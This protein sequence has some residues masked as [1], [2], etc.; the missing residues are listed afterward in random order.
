MYVFLDESGDLGFTLDQPYR[1]GGSSRYL[2]ISFLLI[3]K[4]LLQ[5]PKRIVKKIY[6]K[7]KRSAK[8]ELKGADL[9]ESENIFVAK[10]TVELINKNPQ[11]R[12]FAITVYKRNVADHIRKDPNKL[13]N[14]M[15]SL[16]LLNRI[17]KEKEIIFVP[18]ARSIKVQSGNSLV[19]YLQ[20]ELW[21]RLKSNTTIV[22]HPQES[23]K[24]LNLQF[25]DFL[26][27]IIWIKY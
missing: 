3:P 9:N 8:N 24:Y 13:Y 16:A 23:H 11:I 26:T 25:I 19:E 10:K 12:I 20:T 18:D 21:F 4:D 2:T 7:R 5:L 17:K 15:V 14:Y 1:E 22:N 27:H 6:N